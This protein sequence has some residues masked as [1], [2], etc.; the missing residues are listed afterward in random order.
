LV[1]GDYRIDNM[2]F[3]KT[4]AECLAVLDWE[5]STIG[6]PFADLAAVIMQWSMQ[7]SKEGRGLAGIDRNAQGLM[8]DFEFIDRYCDIR[9]IS[10]IEN[11]G[12][13]L[14][15]CFFRMGGILQGVKKRALDGNASNPERALRVGSYV[16]DCA[17]AGL[18]AAKTI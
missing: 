5:L 16:N 17:N 13:Y 3:S 4:G 2:I 11:F 15:F 9:G 6:H 8:E 1:H 7:T 14:A 10:G 12:F 18:K